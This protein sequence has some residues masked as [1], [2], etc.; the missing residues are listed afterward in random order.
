MD[1]DWNAR[2][3]MPMRLI[4]QYTQKFGIPYAELPVCTWDFE[5]DGK[6]ATL[7]TKYGKK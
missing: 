1:E 3:N 7:I 6:I 2:L 5:F 4:T